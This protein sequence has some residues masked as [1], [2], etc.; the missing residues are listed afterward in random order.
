MRHAM[1]IR[2]VG[3]SAAANTPRF[4]ATSLFRGKDGRWVTVSRTRPCERGEAPRRIRH[5][6]CD[7]N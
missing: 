7:S 2:S 1:G 5:P 3:L 4:T 6:A